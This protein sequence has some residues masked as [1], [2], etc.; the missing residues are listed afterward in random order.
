MIKY[1]KREFFTRKR[2]GIMIYRSVEELIGK[3]PLLE[4]SRIAEGGARVLAKI[5]SKNPFGSAKDRIAMQMLDAAEAEGK[6]GRGSVIIEPTSGNT[7]IALAAL[8]AVRGYRAIIVMPDT[9]SEERIKLMR[10]YGAEVVLTPGKDGMAGS[11]KRAMELRDSIEGGFIPS[12]FENPDNPEAH[13]KTTGPEIYNDT[14]GKVDI[15]VAG[16]GTGGTITGV[17]RYLKEKNPDCKI[18]GVEPADSPFITEK[19][20]GAHKLQGIGAGFLPG[21]LSLEFVDR[22]MT[23]TTEDAYFATRELAR[24]EG[25]LSGISSGAALSAAL[26]LAKA[27]ENKGKTIVV[28]LPD[29]GDKY[30]SVD[31]LF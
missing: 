11:I 4:L 19:K 13:Y 2:S 29:G 21:A 10:A 5:E 3:T 17:G 15:F 12:Q 28:L 9:M 18:I 6:I 26:E 1:K 16:I 27:P 22:V 14:D 25:M 7:G 30:L 20:A 8:A 31:G 24:V 23:R